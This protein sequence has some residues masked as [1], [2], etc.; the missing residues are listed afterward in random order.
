MS[1]NNEPN[2][3]IFSM[4]KVSKFYDK[5]P[6]L[7]D[8]YLSFFYGAK[9][10]V[11]G[12]NGS[13]KSS[14]LRIIAGADKEFNGEVVFS[15]GY[16]VGYLEQE[17]KLDESKTV[18]Q[19][20]EE[21]VQGTVDLLKEFEEINLKF[22]EPMTDDEMNALIERQGE[23]QEKLD[24]SDAWDL[25]SR[26]E[27]AMD[28][29]RCPPPETLIKTLSG[30]EKRRVALCRLLLQKPDILL[31]DEPTNHLDAE[32]VAWLEQ[33]L[34]KYEGTIIAVTH[35]RYFLDNVAGWILEL[36][37]GEGIPWKGNYSSWLEQKQNRL[38]QEQKTE[39]KRQKTL[40]REL[41]WIRMSPKGRHAKSKARINDYEQMVAEGSE[42]RAEDLEIFIPPGERLGDIV[43]EAHGVSKAYGEKLLFENLEFSLP[44]GGIVGVIGP[45]GAGKT[46]LFRLIT[47]QDAADA[48]T[49]KVGETVKLGYVDQSRDSLNADKTIFDEISD[50]LDLV[51]LGRREMN[52]R[53][54]VSRF[55][56]SGSDQQKRVG[57]LSG[58]ERNRVHLAKMLKSGAN[59]ILL[60]EPTNDLDVN[61][62]RALEEALENFAGCAV[63]ISHDRWFLDRIATHI[64]AFE[65]DSKVVY[66]DGNYSEYEADKK[67]RLG[68]DADQPHRI[69]Y[70]SLTRA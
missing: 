60:D 40:E 49:F 22:A 62:M 46:T 57:M 4:V 27:M 7:K 5:K 38:A 11:L 41:E 61:T 44:R 6:V 66:F 15:K 29:L 47:E 67:R 55:N 26:L 52:S 31:L 51:Q 23:V 48:G 10:G 20:V 35:D 14:L 18:R 17:P 53:A 54:Y 70:R 36:D 30:G 3:I 2:K 39:D 25:D 63:V 16:S 45:N 12:L 56:F 65:G 8:I 68:H 24:A 1:N 34:Q 69:K 19:I 50:G 33:H 42:K 9:I 58:G 64:L 21:A 13:G 37:R 59:V 28:A 43:I 32:T